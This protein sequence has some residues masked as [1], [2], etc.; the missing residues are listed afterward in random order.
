MAIINIFGRSSIEADPLCIRSPN[1]PGGQINTMFLCSSSISWKPPNLSDSA[2][3]F[4]GSS[5][6]AITDQKFY[7]S[8]QI[9]ILVGPTYCHPFS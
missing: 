1:R 7:K 5:R 3:V 6:T 8:A 4:T 2:T 9:D